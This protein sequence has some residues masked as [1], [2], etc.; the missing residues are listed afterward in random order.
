MPAN[1]LF[2][3]FLHW[4]GGFASASFYV[5]YKGVRRWSWEIYWL[6]GGIF[7][8]LLA[9]WFFAALGTHDLVGVLAQTPP[10]VLGACVLFGALWG[11]G[12][13]GYGLTMRYLGL[14]LGMA[15]VLGLCTAFGT[16]IPPLVSGEFHEKLLAHTPGRIVLGGIVLTLVGIVV[17]AWAGSLKERDMSAE[18]AKAAI[19]EFD[20]RKGLIVA[21]LSGIMSACFAYGLA[22]GEPI[23]QLSAKAGTGP[24]WTGLPV[25]CVVLLGGLVTNLVWCGFLVVKNRSAGQ[26]LGRGEAG[27][28]K[29]PIARNYALCA[30]AGVAWYFQ[31]FFYTM[32]ESQMG[33]Y[34]FS[35]WT[36]HMASIIIF[37]TLWGFALAEWRKAK[38]ATRAVVWLGV[39]LL[40]L[41][42]VVIGYG[43]SLG[44]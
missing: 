30:L 25:L 12:G 44:A 34:G 20:Y 23:R 41:A 14:S 39:T 40:V 18:D 37:G 31:F 28:A 16:L 1:P 43:N 33:R 2:G 42:T 22:A 21:I 7:S 32:G 6:A 24:L 19:A 8:W 3:V 26:W 9:P 10:K 36:L 11:F 35:S 27:E 29:T 13:L 17:V 5:P 38:A 15:V 4:L